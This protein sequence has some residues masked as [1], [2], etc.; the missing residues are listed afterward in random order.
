M[1]GNFWNDRAVR[2][3]LGLGGKSSSATY[4]AISTDTRTIAKDDLFVALK[5]DQFDGHNFLQAA[6]EAGASG[7]IVTDLPESAPAGMKLYQV[8][9]TLTALGQLAHHKRKQMKARVIAVVGS[10]GKT[11]TK[12]LIPDVRDRGKSE[13]PD[14][15]SPHPAGRP[16]R[17]RGG[18]GGDGHR[19]AG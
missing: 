10:N 19:S 8:A 6:A 5:G 18:G 11:T 13:Q 4:N 3:A 17:C 7:A 2:E 9:D 12:E 14:R 16:R 15:G 1:S